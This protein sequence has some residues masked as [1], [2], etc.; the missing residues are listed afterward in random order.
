MPPPTI[1][2]EVDLGQLLGGADDEAADDRAG[3]RVEAAQDQHRQ[4]LQRDEGQRELHA[5]ARAPD[6]A[7]DQRDEAGDRPDDRP[8]LLQRNA[9]R[10]RRLV[11][12]GDRAQ[13][14]ADARRLEQER[15]Q[16]HQH[17]GDARGEQ[18]ELA[19]C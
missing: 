9:D 4:R 5:V 14:A 1:G 16:R 2:P 18:V 13:R 15:E 11:I 7:G 19:T 10:E 17:A 12:V 8:D 6:E 3:D